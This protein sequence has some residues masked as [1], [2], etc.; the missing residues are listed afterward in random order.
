MVGTTAHDMEIFYLS[1]RGRKTKDF[2]GRMGTWQQS[3][4]AKI[5]RDPRR[6]RISRPKRDPHD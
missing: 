4:E 5:L 1:V 2:N 6:Q 3:R